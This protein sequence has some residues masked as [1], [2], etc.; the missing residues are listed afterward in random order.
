[1]AVKTVEKSLNPGII[2][3]LKTMLIKAFILLL[4]ILRINI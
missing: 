3:K 4:A 1:M 2:Y